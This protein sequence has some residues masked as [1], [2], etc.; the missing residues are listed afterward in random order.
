MITIFTYFNVFV[1]LLFSC[2][3]G[4]ELTGNAIDKVALLKI[5]NKFSQ[6]REIR[7]LCMD[8]GLDR[9]SHLLFHNT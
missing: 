8:N 2:I 5:L 9:E 3:L 1:N 7:L 4:A 6:K